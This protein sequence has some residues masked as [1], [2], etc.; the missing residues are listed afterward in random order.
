MKCLER[1]YKRK[2]SDHVIGASRNKS[3]LHNSIFLFPSTLIDAL[4]TFVCQ[5][6]HPLYAKQQWS[7]WWCRSRNYTNN[8]IQQGIE[9]ISTRISLSMY[10]KNNVRRSWPNI[11]LFIMKA[12]LR[13][14]NNRNPR[15][16][17][18]MYSRD[19][20]QDSKC[21]PRQ[22]LYNSFNTHG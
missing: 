2:G 1:Y 14:L 10:T 7:M 9:S 11:T 16:T 3:L 22:C 18:I 6:N 21:T 8:S 20:A 19:P 15:I 12:L 4:K 17:L 5:F 13:P